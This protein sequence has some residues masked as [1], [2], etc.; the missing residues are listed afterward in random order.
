MTN[1]VTG[2]PL[3]NEEIGIALVSL[4]FASSVNSTAG[5]KN[6]LAFL[7]QHPSSLEA[8]KKESSTLL[9]NGDLKSI[10][11]FNY[12]NC[13]VLE[14]CRLSSNAFAIERVPRSGIVGD[15]FLG[16]VDMVSI[17]SSLL[18]FEDPGVKSFGLDLT[19]FNP[20]RFLE[21]KGAKSS[22]LT[23]GGT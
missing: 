13:C 14:A 10:L 1:S 21:S 16:D 4:L 8:A 20:Q 9:S 7:C 15:Y 23:W 6:T 12:L 3:S 11:S 19:E 22:I 18:H 2:Q 17:G 5:F